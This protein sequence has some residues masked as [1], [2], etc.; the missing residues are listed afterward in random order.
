MGEEVLVQRQDEKEAVAAGL[1][2]AIN[3]ILY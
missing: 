1:V 2:Y 3:I